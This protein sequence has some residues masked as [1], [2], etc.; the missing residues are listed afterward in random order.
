MMDI[1]LE[2]LYTF[3]RGHHHK[4][5]YVL[6]YPHPPDYAKVAQETQF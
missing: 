1:E 3:D 5:I 6:Q 2:A 4:C